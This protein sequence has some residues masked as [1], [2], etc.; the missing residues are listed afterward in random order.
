M[1]G[2]EE[3]K[4]DH[5]RGHQGRDKEAKLDIEFAR[6]QDARLGEMRSY[7]HDGQVAH[8]WSLALVDSHV[9]M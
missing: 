3:N 6:A 5:D 8:R 4:Q 9:T 2:D 1:K 7:T